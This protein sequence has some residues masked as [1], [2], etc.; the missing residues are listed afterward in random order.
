MCLSATVREII[1]IVPD[2]L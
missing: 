2:S 1:S